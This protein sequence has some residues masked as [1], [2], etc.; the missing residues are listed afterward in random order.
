M[1]AR[2]SGQPHK[3]WKAAAKKYKV[4]EAPTPLTV[5]DAMVDA[6]LTA[7]FASPPSETDMGLARSMRAAI[8]ASMSLLVSRP[9]A[10]QERA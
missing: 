8:K 1:T 3:G 5:T 7:W 9:K 6:A 4:I 2:K 10:S